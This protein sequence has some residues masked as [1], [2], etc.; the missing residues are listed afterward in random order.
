MKWNYGNDPAY[1]V[2]RMLVLKAKNKTNAL[3]LSERFREFFI[4]GGWK[5]LTGQSS[6]EISIEAT[7]EEDR[8]FWE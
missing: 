8:P 7:E 1:D 2:Q 5:E 3:E 6:S 4:G